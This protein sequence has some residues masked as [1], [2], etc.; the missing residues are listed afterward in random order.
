[1]T[2]A[3]AAPDVAI[4]GGG[5]VGTAVAAFLAEAGVRVRL[6]ERSAIAAGASGR[7][8]GIVQHPFDPVLADLYRRSL[9]AYRPLGVDLD[10][11]FGLPSSPSGL[12]FIGRD[13]SVPPTT[14]RRGGQHGPTRR[15]TVIAGAE[16]LALEPASPA[17]SRRV[18][19]RSAIPSRRRRPPMRS[20]PSR[21][22]PARR[23]SRRVG[24][25][26][27]AGRAR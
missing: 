16:L 13:R 20:R 26:D 14:P 1:M 2:G 12:L 27:D 15:L 6:Y 24:G 3:R 18:G 5:I 21:V 17:A 7:N 8:S 23:S 4:I 25:A 9:A 10:G 11:A 19:S 22:A